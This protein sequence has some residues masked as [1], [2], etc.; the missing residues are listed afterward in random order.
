MQ[1][2]KTGISV[3]LMAALIYFFGII[4][5]TPMVL[6]AGYVLLVENDEWLKKSAVKALVIV[7]V[8]YIINAIFGLGDNIFTFFNYFL[9]FLNRILPFTI[10]VDYPLSLDSVVMNIVSLVKNL[11]LLI[12]G[13]Q[14]FSQ[15][16]FKL[17]MVDRFIDKHM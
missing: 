5:I 16:S 14:A 1:K 12:L 13:F 6:L 9:G 15:K 3:G 11:L 17:P 8:Y 10:R 4:S 2:A 7:V